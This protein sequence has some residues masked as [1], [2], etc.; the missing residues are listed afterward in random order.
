MPSNSIRMVCFDV[1]GVLIKHH[2]TWDAGC[3]AAG[4]PVRDGAMSP[5]LAAHRRE[6]TAAYT[7]GRIPCETFYAEMSRLMGG[8][9]SADEVRRVHH[10]WLGPE[11]DGVAA[12]MHR[13]ISVNWIDTGVLSNTNPAHWARMNKTE[14]RPAEFPSPAMLRHRHA[15]HLLGFAKPDPRAFREFERRTDYRGAEILYFDD[16]VENVETARAQGW[17][18]EHIDHTADTAAQIEA[19]LTRHGIF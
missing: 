8:L 11:Y 19:A 12:V 9:Y 5:D 4:L 7:T 10:H 6:V 2:R 3:T 18:V 13:L 15:S 16:L 17:I 14:I 1:G